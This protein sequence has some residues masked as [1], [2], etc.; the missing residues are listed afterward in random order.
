MSFLDKVKQTT[1]QVAADLKKG[2]AQVQTKVGQL[3]LRRK[4]DE[5]AKDLGYLIVRERTTG[6]RVSDEVDRLVAAIVDLERQIEEAKAA[7]EAEAAR[8]AEGGGA[9]AGTGPAD[10]APPAE[11]APE[12]GGGG[13]AGG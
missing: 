6:A 10:Q 1:Q 5:H 4:A 3:Q 12:Q 9:A 8:A 7:E 11:G 13:Q 2:A